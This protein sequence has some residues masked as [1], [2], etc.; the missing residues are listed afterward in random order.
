MS[1]HLGPD[2]PE[3]RIRRP[4]TSRSPSPVRSCSPTRA[5]AGFTY[6][7]ALFTRSAPV[8]PDPPAEGSLAEPGYRALVTSY[9]AMSCPTIPRHASGTPDDGGRSGSVHANLFC[10]AT[11]GAKYVSRDAIGRVR[12]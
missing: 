12:I 7:G 5:R 4:L 9:G 3:V 2:P 11:R 10:I 6:F 8:T 1:V